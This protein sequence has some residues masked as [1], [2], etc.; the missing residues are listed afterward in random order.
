[1]KREDFLNALLK[2]Y[3]NVNNDEVNDIHKDGFDVTSNHNKCF[4]TFAVRVLTVTD[5]IIITFGGYG[6]SF[7]MFHEPSDLEYYTDEF[8]KYIKGCEPELDFEQ[9]YFCEVDIL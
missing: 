4:F 3:D 8:E 1:M 6:L 5:D 9:L 2:A 7:R